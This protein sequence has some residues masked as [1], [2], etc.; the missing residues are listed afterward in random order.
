[1]FDQTGNAVKGNCRPGGSGLM[2]AYQTDG[3]IVVAGSVIMMVRHG[4]KRGKKEQQYQ[5]NSKALMS[6]HDASFKHK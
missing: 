5:K 2:M 1:L 3:T 6:V 4:H